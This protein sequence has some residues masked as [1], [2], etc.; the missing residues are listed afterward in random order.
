ML[1]QGLCYATVTLRTGAGRERRAS[2]CRAASSTRGGGGCF[3][4]RPIIINV[5]LGCSKAPSQIQNNLSNQPITEG[6]KT[7]DL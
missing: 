7:K 2:G 1:L 6:I 3:T 5:C 4:L